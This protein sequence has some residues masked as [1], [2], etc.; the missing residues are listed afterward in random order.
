MRCART[1]LALV[2]TVSVAMGMAA[3]SAPTEVVCPSIYFD[4]GMR[5]EVRRQ[6]GVPIG[7][8]THVD[9]LGHMMRGGGDSSRVDSYSPRGGYRSVGADSLNIFGAPEPGRFVIRVMAPGYLDHYRV[10]QVHAKGG[11]NVKTTVVK[12]YLG[13]S[14]PPT[15]VRSLTIH[16]R[17]YPT[18]LGDHTVP[19]FWAFVD[20]QPGVSTAVTWRSSN[21]SRFP[22]DANGRMTRAVCGK[23]DSVVVY[24]LA[25]ADT[26]KRDSVTA[27]DPY[28]DP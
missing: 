14:T 13:P 20:A 18:L 3:C 10:V 7:L 1:I 6:D 17:V 5:I 9:I 21:P 4:P 8:A 16:S 26:T 12:V 15:P 25:K 27:W 11:C 22:I 2:T 19:Y 24:A 28:C 23:S